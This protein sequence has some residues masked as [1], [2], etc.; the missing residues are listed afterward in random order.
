[1]SLIPT[2]HWIRYKASQQPTKSEKIQCDCD[3]MHTL[4]IFGSVHYFLFPMLTCPRF[5]CRR[6]VSSAVNLYGRLKQLNDAKE[7]QGTLDLFNQHVRQQ[8]PTDLAIFQALKACIELGDVQ[9]ASS[10]HRNLSSESMNNSFIL[11]NLI[12]LFCKY[13]VH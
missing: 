13:L 12:R 1:M 8:S 2:A 6:H 4:S 10:I 7:F 5:I 3:C 11:T 9:L